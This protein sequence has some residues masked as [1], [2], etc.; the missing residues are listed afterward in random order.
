[1][2]G[3]RRAN[4]TVYKIFIEKCAKSFELCRGKG[5]YGAERRRSTFLEVDLEIIRAMRRQ[6]VG[7]DL[8]EYICELVILGWNTG[9]IDGGGVSGRRAKVSTFGNV[10]NTE[11]DGTFHF[12]SANVGGC[13]DENHR[14]RRRISGVTRRSR[15]SGLDKRRSLARER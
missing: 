13:V 3:G 2:G 12:C 9:E 1:M 10:K 5:I 11:L 14:R 4:D 7:L 15:R 8:V 6:S